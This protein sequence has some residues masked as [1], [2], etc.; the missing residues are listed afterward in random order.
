MA[1]AEAV[2]FAKTG[3]LADVCAALPRVI[4]GL[5]HSVS[6]FLPA[7]QSVFKAGLSI[8]P[9]GIG[10]PIS[11]GDQQTACRIL[12]HQ[13]PDSGVNFY[14]V[15]QP[16]L[17]DRPGLYGDDKGDYPDNLRRFS[18][19]ARS[20]IQAIEALQLTPDIVHCHDWQ[21]GL[22]P[23]YI[24]TRYHGHAWMDRAG[25]VTTIHNLAYQG[26]FSPQDMWLT[27]L[28]WSH[29]N[30]R[31]LEFYGDVCLLKSGI[32]FADHVTTVSPTYAREIQTPAFGCGLDNVLKAQ[33]NQL[34]GIVNG[35]D[36]DLWEPS[37]DRQ[38]TS[39]FSVSDWRPGK[40]AN[41]AA[42]QKELGL[43]IN[44]TTPL[45]GLVGRLADQ[46]G[47]DLII[48]MLQT[49]IQRDDVQW[50]ILGSGDPRF[51]S[52]LQALADRAP[53]KLSVSMTFSDALAHKIEAGS[54]I[55]LMPSAYEPCGLNQLYS[56]R[57]G[58]IPVVHKTGGLAD[59]V[60][61]T[62]LSTIE[63]QTA[64]GFV[65]EDYNVSSLDQTLRR[66]CT[67]LRNDPSNWNVIVERGML[68]DWSWSQSA[69]AYAAV[70]ER[71]RRR[72]QVE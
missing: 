36:Y 22:I 33:A 1:T 8:Q 67:M 64:T 68:Q 31:E 53:D 70:Y 3:G 30:W 2:P 14:F 72:I 41:K 65:F 6:V 18:F 47:W 12:H 21:A 48:P 13:E 24:K 26:R 52:S 56:L 62:N 63:L 7:Y 60:T 69:H 25:V 10:F 51:E 29:F 40:A 16:Q 59:T 23:A 44:P 38:I 43:A 45:I 5:G 9:T 37:I 28:D 61:D 50:A 19:F 39:N 71:V 46:K 55:F 17:F 4:A 35:V 20:V 27:G 66:A 49:A 58:T 11:F 34:S 42:L 32:V 15:D 57:Y 54:D